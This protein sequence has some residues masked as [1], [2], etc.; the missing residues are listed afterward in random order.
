MID[1]VWLGGD[2][3]PEWD[4]GAVYHVP[5]PTPSAVTDIVERF[6]A[7]SAAV[8]WVFRDAELG[9]PD[10]QHVR[11]LLEGPA[12]AWHAG[13][14]LGT[15]GAP[16]MIDFV[17]PTWMMNRDPDPTRE[18]TSWRVSLRAAVVRTDVLRQ[19]GGPAPDF[20]SL[21]A[22]SLELGHRWI[23]RGVFVRHD[24]G[25]VEGTSPCLT[26][27]EFSVADELRF[28][29]YRFGR[30]WTAWAVYRALATG[31]APRAEILR[32]WRGLRS[33]VPPVD[34]APY[35]RPERMVPDSIARRVSVLVPTLERYPYLRTV[36]GQL[37]GQTVPPL[38][39]IV[40]DQTPPADRD[41]SIETW[42]PGLP[43]RV[44]TLDEPGQCT[45]RNTGLLMAEGDYVLFIDD[46][47]EIEPDLIE[48]HLCALDRYGADV[49]SGVADEVG[50]GPLPEAFTLTRAA[51]VFPTN[52]SLIRKSSLEGSGLFDLAYDRGQRADGDLGTRLYLSGALMVLDPSISVFHHHAPRGG[53]RAHRARV[54]TYASSRGTVRQR[55]LPSVSEIYLWRRYFSARQVRE[56]LHL[57]V[58]GT[59]SI[60]AGWRRRLL[61]AAFS[62][63]ALPHSVRTVRARI[64]EAD[65]MLERFPQIPSLP[66]SAVAHEHGERA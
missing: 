18:A 47:D 4:G 64:R 9:R 33:A 56:A 30:K 23:R 45:S 37:A 13:L 38:E 54:I 1:L 39:V 36:L 46:D 40:V 42:V 63:A 34:P 10:E 2:T 6:A 14:L 8:A 25:L 20:S 22:A 53:L 65:R 60:R 48:R 49:S 44:I 55:H 19:L 29:L 61:K 57:G 50:A 58:F 5:E 7:D 43:V 31:Y 24:P 26:S 15:G 41:P 17:Q 3:P 21:A 16:G 32:A 62:A 66:D 27:E 12:D 35:L 59:F 52:N 51:D 11:R 28:V